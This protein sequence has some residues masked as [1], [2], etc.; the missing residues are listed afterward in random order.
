MSRS[1]S[2]GV[3]D[4]HL[5]GGFAFSGLGNGRSPDGTSAELAGGFALLRDTPADMID[6]CG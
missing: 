6:A 3:E 1:W 4:E 5:D 2:L